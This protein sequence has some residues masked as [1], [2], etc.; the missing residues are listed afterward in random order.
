MGSVDEVPLTKPVLFSDVSRED[1]DSNSAQ[2]SNAPTG[3]AYALP[4]YMI[5]YVA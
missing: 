5:R 3:S 2:I 4:M 1:A